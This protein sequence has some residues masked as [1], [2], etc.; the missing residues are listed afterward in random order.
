MPAFEVLSPD[1]QSVPFVF[2]SP[3][4]G[5]TYLSSFL[6]TSRLDNTQI[7][8]SEDAFVDLLIKDA[9]QLG[10]PI[11]KANFPRAYIDVN[12]EAYELDPKMFEG[13]LPK[14]INSRSLRVAGGLGTIARIVGEQREIYRT[15]IPAAEGLDRIEQVY[16]PYHSAL[17]GL[18]D[19]VQEQFGLA[20]LVDCHS[21]PSAN[22]SKHNDQKADFVIGDRFGTSCSSWLS[23]CTVGLLQ[24]MGYH[25]ALNRPYAGGYITENYGKPA[26][27][28]HAIQVEINRS[29][30][31]DEH[32]HEPHSGF[33]D[34]RQDLM[35]FLSALVAMVSENFSKELL[36]AE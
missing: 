19:D 29:L 36:A 3:H 20:V 32:T 5:R 4:S 25:V 21:M 12:R 30:Y 26:R 34:L 2:N 31:M 24:N 14:H 9:Q 15:R 11:L 35:E 10:A 22:S 17:R 7:R 33:Q 16:K 28:V 6:Q 18:L 1:R 8:Q 27:G 23:S 13:A